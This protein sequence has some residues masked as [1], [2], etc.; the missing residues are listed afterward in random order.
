MPRA[1]TAL[2]IT[3]I[4][5][6][7]VVLGVYAFHRVRLRK[8]TYFTLDADQRQVLNE[9]RAVY[10]AYPAVTFAE[11]VTA[12]DVM[13]VLDAA[14]D[15]PVPPATALIPAT[16]TP[17]EARR[18]RAEIS[19]LMAE[20]L[21]YAIVKQDADAYITWRLDRGDRLPT[22][23]E[24]E[25]DTALTETWTYLTGEPP[26]DDLTS[27]EI[28]RFLL[29]HGRAQATPARRVVGMLDHPD[30][31]F[32]QLW[33]DNRHVFFTP[34]FPEPLGEHGWS[35]S[36]VAGGAGH[37]IGP[38]TRHD[39]YAV[40]APILRARCGVILVDAG[41]LRQ[42]LVLYAYRS[43]DDA[44]WNIDA[45]HIGNADPDAMPGWSW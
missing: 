12:A 32:T 34:P 4:A 40:A 11:S 30:A 35:G 10:A 42:P 25:R 39:L 37:L 45:V 19:R 7:A 44:H 9:A 33:F 6:A 29:E 41:G 1:R 18:H 38:V 8:P 43:P 15:Q 27:R 23:D 14:P 16:L 3:L 2:P 17:D 5:L 13:A 36:Q 22:R 26:A 31:A 20:F 24:L 28:V 21:L